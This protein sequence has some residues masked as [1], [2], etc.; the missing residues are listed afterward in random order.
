MVTAAA[1]VV[2]VVVAVKC[3]WLAGQFLFQGK[4]DFISKHNIK[5]K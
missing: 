5:N 3:N 2:V 1:V 4:E